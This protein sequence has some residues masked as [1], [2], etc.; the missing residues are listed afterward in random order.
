LYK[1]HMQQ[2]GNDVANN[3][4]REIGRAIIGAVMM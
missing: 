2:G 1:H 3:Q 4:D